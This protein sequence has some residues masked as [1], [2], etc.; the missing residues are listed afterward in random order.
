MEWDVDLDFEYDP[1]EYECPRR[2][3]SEQVEKFL[4]ATACQTPA[5]VVF[6]QSN[7]EQT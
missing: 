3:Y 7:Q 1:G 2:V 4:F 5:P 6:L